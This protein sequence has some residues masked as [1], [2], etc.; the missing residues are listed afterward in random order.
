MLRG[1]K[2]MTATQQMFWFQKYIQSSQLMVTSR[3]SFAHN[4]E[5]GAHQVAAHHG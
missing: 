3:R 4:E 5:H 1:N 2:L